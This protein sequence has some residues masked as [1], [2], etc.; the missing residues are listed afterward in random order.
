MGWR[1]NSEMRESGKKA[2]QRLRTMGRIAVVEITEADE[3][4]GAETL[5]TRQEAHVRD[6]VKFRLGGAVATIGS[7]IVAYVFEAVLEEVAF[8]QLEGDL[9]LDEELTADAFEI[10][11]KQG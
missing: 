9:I 11:Q 2:S 4:Q 1:W 8:R 5:T 7:D 3:V 6:E 10:F